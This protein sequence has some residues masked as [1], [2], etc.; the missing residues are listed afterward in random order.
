MQFPLRIMAVSKDE[1][2]S[3]IRENN[4]QLM[5]FYLLKQT[6]GEIKSANKDLFFKWISQSSDGL[7]WKNINSTI[8]LRMRN[9]LTV[10]K[11]MP[12]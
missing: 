5:A 6:V 9:R 8:S 7:P 1:V 2:S 12:K 4:E 3:L 11:D 10:Q